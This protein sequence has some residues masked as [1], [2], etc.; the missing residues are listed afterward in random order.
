[1]PSSSLVSI[2]TPA[3]N[4]ATYLL[5][6][7]HSVQAQTW[8]EWEMI[9]VDD[10]SQDQTWEVLCRAAAEDQRIRPLRAT[11]KLGVSAA[12]NAALDM[13]TGRYVAFLDSD[14]IWHSDKLD[15]QLDF[16]REN[17]VA[18]S[19]TDYDHIDTKGRLLKE[20]TWERE[21]YN[22]RQLL[23]FNGIGCLTVVIDQGE[24]GPVR[25]MAKGHEDYILWL[26]ILKKGVTA[27]GLQ[28][29]LA[30][31]RIGDHSLSRNKWRAARWTW[32]IYRRTEG[33]SMP[34][35]L[36]HFSN[37]F[38]RSLAKYYLARERRK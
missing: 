15:H 33:L 31:H 32:Q 20:S 29:V 30:H 28:E 26:Q 37:Y 9:I 5:T 17:A 11:S 12:R 34:V 8:T 25:F 27:H 23:N 35:A 1:M 6:T 14:D 10:C 22:Y 2:I 4:A 38:L 19:F 18:F 16:M 13:A 21:S 36:R 24:I 3:F 7:I